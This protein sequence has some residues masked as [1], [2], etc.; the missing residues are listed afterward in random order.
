MHTGP[1]I[2]QGLLSL[3]LNQAI[4][5]E[6]SASPSRTEYYHPEKSCYVN[7]VFYTQCKDRH[8]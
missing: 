1:V 8:D 2:L 4:L 3:C 7:G 5:C 6:P